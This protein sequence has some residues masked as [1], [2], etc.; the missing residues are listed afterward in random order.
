MKYNGYVESG[1]M[2]LDIGDIVLITHVDETDPSSNETHFGKKMKDGAV[3]EDKGWF[4]PKHVAWELY[5]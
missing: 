4:P 1:Y 2:H 3:S 5:R